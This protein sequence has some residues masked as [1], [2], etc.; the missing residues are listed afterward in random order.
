MI[1]FGHDSRG[2]RLLPANGSSSE[3]A[4]VALNIGYYYTFLLIF[5][6]GSLWAYC[7]L[8]LNLLEK[9][10]EARSQPQPPP[11]PWVERLISIWATT[12]FLPFVLAYHL[13][14]AVFLLLYGLY[15]LSGLKLPKGPPRLEGGEKAGWA[16]S[17]ELPA[18]VVRLRAW[19]RRLAEPTFLFVWPPEKPGFSKL[20]GR[21][22]LPVD[23]AWPDGA[24]GPRQFLLQIDL[25]ELPRRKVS[26]PGCRRKAVFM[27]FSIDG[28]ILTKL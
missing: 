24:R 16:S 15:K 14:R 5:G 8:I 25:S 23:V 20:G 2:E 9:R 18:N 12:V 22:E 28:P 13:L 3:L 21:P 11:I 6:M 1:I 7:F 27:R 4:N 26:R 10:R 17:S 19:M